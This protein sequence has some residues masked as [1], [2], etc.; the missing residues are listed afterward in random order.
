[1]SFT[2]VVDFPQPVSVVF[3]LLADPRR[4]PE[5][6]SSLR[7]VELLA[8]DEPAVGSR[9]YDVT[10]VG[11]R[12]L[13]EITAWET[14]RYWAERG[15]W[16]GVEV[17]LEL[18]FDELPGG[19]RVRATATTRAPGWRRPVGLALAALGPMAARSDLRR[20]ARLLS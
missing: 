6:Q 4:R 11:V 3:A 12:P 17:E 13:M 16:R 8:E 5:W 18:L 15:R 7:G 9:W 1:M 10:V 2:V 20:A 19:S 14:D